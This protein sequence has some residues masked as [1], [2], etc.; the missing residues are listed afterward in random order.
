MNDG[1][2]NGFITIAGGSLG[3]Y[4]NTSAIISQHISDGG[5]T[6]NIKRG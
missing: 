6:M 2:G 4:L 5:F 3:T 1:L